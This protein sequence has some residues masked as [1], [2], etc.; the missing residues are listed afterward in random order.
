MTGLAGLDKAA[1]MR[2]DVTCRALRKGKSRVLD[3]RLPV[4]HR[5]VA[6]RA[7]NFFVRASQGIFRRC[8]IK[9]SRGLP[10]IRG[11]ATRTIS[12]DLSAMLV[13]VA[14]YAV[15]RKAEISPV[16]V[17]DEDVRARRRRDVLHL[18]ALFARHARVL[19]RECE[20]GLTV[21]HRFP[22]GLPM[23]ELKINAVVLRVAL[24]AILAR[25]GRAHPNGVYPAALLNSLAD[26]R[27][28]IKALE[29]R[30]APGQ[31]MT[32]GAVCGTR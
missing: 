7:G 17:L 26:L 2:I 28:A 12:A 15:V 24:G 13:E 11:V 1:F 9:E 16:Q 27:M 4:R 20:A 32:L 19:P 5:R 30:S 18:M 14:A 25:S 10:A 23:D 22:T 29:L 8:M 3:E 21:V 31:V 6:L